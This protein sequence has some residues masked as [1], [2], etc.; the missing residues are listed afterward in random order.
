MCPS[1]LIPPAPGYGKP[2]QFISPSDSAFHSGVTTKTS[3]VVGDE[4]LEQM[5][6]PPPNT[7]IS[8]P[9]PGPLPGQY[10]FETYQKPGTG[11]C[12]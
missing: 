8:Q 11:S 12:I 3:S 1:P 10:P 7:V 6:E 9:G 5:D 4:D 2:G